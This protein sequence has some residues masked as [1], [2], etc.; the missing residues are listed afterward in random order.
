MDR[1]AI[2]DMRIPDSPREY[3][4]R[5]ID[6]LAGGVA[7]FLVS[8]GLKRGQRIAI[9]S[10][11]RAEYVAAYFGIMRAGM[12]AVPVNVKLALPT[13]AHI[14]RD[15]DI[16]LAFVD[17]EREQLLQ[18]DV[19]CVSFDGAGSS[20]SFGFAS[21]VTPCEFESVYA[22]A[23][24]I[25]QILYTSGSTGLPKGVPLEHGGQLHAL[26]TSV[27]S[28]TPEADRYLLAQP[29]YH[30][31]GLMVLKA[32]FVTNAYVVLTPSFNARQYLALLSTHRV[33][34][35]RAVPTMLARV[36]KELEQTPD[37]DLSALKVV[38]LSSSPLTQA[39]IDRI[40][41][42]IAHVRVT[43]GYG[44]TEGGPAVFGPHPSGLVTPD[45]S[46]GYPLPTSEVRLAGGAA[47]DSGILSVRNP[48]VMTGYLGLPKKTAEVLDDGWYTTGDV[49]RRDKDGFFFF[50]GRADDMFVCSGE[51]IY[52]GEVEKMLERHPLVREACVLPLPD[53]ERG[54]VPVAFI[55][56]RPDA[57]LSFND[58]KVHAL[59]HG[60]A[61]QYP[62]RVAFLPQLPWAGTNKI[63]RAALLALA[64][65][66][67]AVA[68]WGIDSAKEVE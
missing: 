28:L 25:A 33:S 7:R 45:L 57:T 67:E 50:V 47:A 39:L 42:A 65:E 58:I 41:A 66:L 60:P 46:V 16:R 5:E 48:V 15:A 9:A 1:T 53:D 34:I 37:S 30:M 63:D 52:P 24:M 68:A 20:G 4:H 29:L 49:M 38:N 11:S 6:R 54:Q 2:V 17:A 56:K 19:P 21:L 59:E 32:V 61:Y 40:R 18:N 13:I 26:G 36:I 55:V 23:G 14:L 22:E 64:R 8:K 35:C 12:V 62:R 43:N 3:S 51:N 27:V 31:N 44:T 10:A